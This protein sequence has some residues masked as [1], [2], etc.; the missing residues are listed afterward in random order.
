MGNEACTPPSKAP[1]HASGDAFVITHWSVVLAAKDRSSPQSDQALETLCRTY[2][3][4]LYV[5]VRRQGRSPHDAQD[6]VQEFF[7]RL[8]QKNYLQAVE[9]ERG[10]FRTFLIMALKRFLANE[11]DRVRAQKRNGGQAPL[12][13]A[14]ELAEGR[15][16]EEASA[17][18]A[19]DLAFDRQ[20]AITLLDQALARVRDEHERLGKRT[21][22]EVLRQFLTVGHE[23]V[24]Y[25]AVAVQLGL[26]EAAVKMAVHRLRQR[27]RAALREAIG[28]TVVCPEDVDAEVRHLLRVLSR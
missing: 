22:F 15:Y 11:W 16:Q 3:Y 23:T 24:P 18:M 20:W 19:A 13:L 26:S 1:A 4:P 14:A 12:P 5:F 7:A 17:E 9:P 27:Y 25:G 21:E 28:E 2:W 8:L 10:R 6:L